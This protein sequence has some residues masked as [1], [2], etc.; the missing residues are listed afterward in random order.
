MPLLSPDSFLSLNLKP[1]LLLARPLAV[2]FCDSFQRLLIT[3][4]LC[5]N[6]FDLLPVLRPQ[7]RDAGLAPPLGLFQGLLGIPH[8]LL[9]LADELLI[10]LHFEPPWLV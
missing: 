4:N 3:S 8:R 6:P 9:E 5:L 2:A 1:F 10:W 7:R